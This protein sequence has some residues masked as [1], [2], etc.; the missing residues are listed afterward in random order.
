MVAR[1]PS[2]WG[3]GPGRTVQSDSPAAAHALRSSDP[4]HDP[5]HNAPDEGLITAD[6]FVRLRVN[7]FANGNS[8]SASISAGSVEFGSG[9]F[10]I[11]DG[12]DSTQGAARRRERSERF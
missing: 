2:A 8:M 3:C 10:F 7:R 4:P 6:N 9:A 11:G 5:R 1:G 12:A